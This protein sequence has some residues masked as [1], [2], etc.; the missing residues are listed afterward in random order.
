M[1]TKT[2]ESKTKSKSNLKAKILDNDSKEWAEISV[3]V[4]IKVSP[5]LKIVKIANECENTLKE[6]KI[7]S[8]LKHSKNQEFND[9]KSL[10]AEKK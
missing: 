4:E 8:G 2:N 7:K 6:S 10:E 9:Q 5:D 3:A 1:E